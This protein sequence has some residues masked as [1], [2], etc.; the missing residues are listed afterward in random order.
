M[1]LGKYFTLE[2]MCRTN[3]R[4]IN[5]PDEGQLVS[6]TRLVTL[7]LDPLR[8]ECGALKVTSGFRSEAVNKAVGGAVRSFHRHGLAADIQSDTHHVDELV[9][10]I[11]YLALPFDKLIMEYAGNKPWLHWQIVEPNRTN[12]KEIYTAK[13]V[14][15]KMKYTQVM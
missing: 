3:T 2:E 9:D 11:E 8:A 6:L 4:A 5:R 14:D 1:E 13:I 7:C 12:R 10:R 15:G